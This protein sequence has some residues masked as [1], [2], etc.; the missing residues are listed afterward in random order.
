MIQIFARNNS[1]ILEWVLIWPVHITIRYTNCKSVLL[2]MILLVS[3]FL[4]SC[5]I[6]EAVSSRSNDQ[7]L[8]F[9]VFG[10][11]AIYVIDPESKTV[12]SKI[13]AEGVC[14]KSNNRYSR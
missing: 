9:Y 12:L 14:T 3:L 5:S 11:E 2:L 10:S 13:E 4:V 8:L 7:K 6:C 1:S